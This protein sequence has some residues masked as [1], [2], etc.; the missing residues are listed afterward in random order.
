MQHTQLKNAFFQ[1][2]QAT[3]L[4]YG[5]IQLVFNGYKPKTHD[6]EHL[7]ALAKA[8]DMEFDK[9]FPKASKEERDCFELL[10]KAYVDARYNMY[11]KISKED[12][13][14]LSERVQLLRKLTEEICKGKIMSFV[15]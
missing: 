8:C 2:H 3:E 11:Y 5:A 9:A 14:Y 4:Y 15:G 10:K 12:L 7:G 1:L 6:I 13:D